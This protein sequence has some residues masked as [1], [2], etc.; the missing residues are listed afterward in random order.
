MIPAAKSLAVTRVLETFCLRRGQG[1]LFFGICRTTATAKTL[2]GALR[3]RRSRQGM[4]QASCYMSSLNRTGRGISWGLCRPYGTRLRC[5][6]AM[7]SGNART[8]QNK[9]PSSCV[10]VQL[11]ARPRRKHRVL[12]GGSWE[13]TGPGTLLLPL[14]CLPRPRSAATKAVHATPGNW[15]QGDA[16]CV[17]A[18]RNLQITA[19]CFPFLFPSGAAGC[20][21]NQEL[22]E[23]P[24]YQRPLIRA[25]R[26]HPSIPHSGAGRWIAI[27]STTVTAVQPPSG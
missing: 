8:F 19:C 4:K 21:C 10:C 7:S 15:K 27:S 14:P 25:V 24:S 22:E 20:S 26:H 9:S 12:G 5:G 11:H 1:K 23:L 17:R 16:S 13:G 18:T 2:R 6:T 3:M